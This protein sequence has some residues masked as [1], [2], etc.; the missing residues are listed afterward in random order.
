MADNQ[1]VGVEELHI[2]VGGMSRDQPRLPAEMAFVPIE[3]PSS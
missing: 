1:Y 2:L 3:K